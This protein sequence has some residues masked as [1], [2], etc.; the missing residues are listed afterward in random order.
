MS[1]ILLVALLSTV[2]LALPFGFNPGRVFASCSPQALLQTNPPATYDQCPIDLPLSCSNSTPVDSSC[3]FESPGGIMLQTQ[4]WDYYPPIGAN[5]SFTLH[6]LWPD[7]CDGTYEQFCDARLN[8]AKDEIKRIVVDE[9]NDSA[10]YAKIE[11]NWK[12][13]NGDDEL[14]WMHE[15]N[16][17]A[18]C[19][20][21]IRPTCY[22]SG[23]KPDEN[24]YDFFRI[25][26]LLYEKYP[27]FEFLADAGITPSLD[28]TYTFD[29]IAE[30]LNSNFDG[31][32]V[33]FKCNKYN[34]LQ[35]IWYYHYLQGP[36]QNEQF[37]K[38]SS[39]SAS[40]CPQTGIKFLPKN[41]FNPPPTQPP[42]NPIGKPGTLR[43]SG[44]SGCLIS[45]GQLY[46]YG[47]CATFRLRDLQFGGKNLVSSKG[48]CGV[49]E[50]G[51]LSCN[52]MNLP[53]RFQFQVDRN[54]GDVSYGGNSDWCLHE[55]GKHG[56][57][58]FVQTPIKVASDGCKSFKLKLT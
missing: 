12:N 8:L 31:H 21:T 33:Y 52:S 27:T 49:D 56:L 45:N 13:F 53:Q 54:S 6:G 48:V 35:E 40:G 43:L 20:K 30:A 10:L 39:L 47:T 1:K 50:S 55:A 3:C 37:V 23:F 2:V 19:I 18:T 41:Q 14:L 29:Q 46:D 11:K 58:R 7:N 32:K 4:F 28:K 17:H 38:I 16:K 5:D 15:F 34:A 44:H 36:L 24:V 22:G 42:K 25:A 51:I 26:V 9:F 57:G